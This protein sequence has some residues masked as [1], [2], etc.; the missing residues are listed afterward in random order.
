MNKFE[1]FAL[2]EWLSDFPENKT[3][4]DILDMIYSESEEVTPW[5]VIELFKPLDIVSIIDQ[6]KTHAEKMLGTSNLN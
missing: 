1:L 3:Y 2:Q 4:K 6:T 5:H